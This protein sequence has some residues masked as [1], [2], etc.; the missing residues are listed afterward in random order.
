MLTEISNQPRTGSARNL[1]RKLLKDAKIAHLPVSLQKVL[2]HLKTKMD[3]EVFSL[4]LGQKISG[5]LVVDQDT[6]TIGFNGEQHWH[7]RR[8]TLAHEICHLLMGHACSG[9]ERSSPLERE[10]NQF[11]G[12]LLMPLKDIKR[13]YA[14]DQNLDNLSAK[15]AVSVQSL[16]IRLMECRLLK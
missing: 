14:L 7:R 12:E 15:Y 3:L 6:A 5:I 1:A 16:C 10:A 2:D 4:S 11:A 9:V 13:D 8:F